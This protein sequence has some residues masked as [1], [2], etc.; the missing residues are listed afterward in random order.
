MNDITGQRCDGD[1]YYLVGLDQT[2]CAGQWESLAEQGLLNPQRA[3]IPNLAEEMPG[4]RLPRDTGFNWL[5]IGPISFQP[6]LYTEYTVKLVSFS[7]NGDRTYGKNTFSLSNLY[8]PCNHGSVDPKIFEI[9]KWAVGKFISDGIVLSDKPDFSKVRYAGLSIK[10]LDQ[11][12]RYGRFDGNPPNTFDG[13]ILSRQNVV[14]FVPATFDPRQDT[15]YDGL[16]VGFDAEK[17]SHFKMITIGLHQ[18][19]RIINTETIPGYTSHQCNK[20]SWLEIDSDSLILPKQFNFGAQD[21]PR[22]SMMGFP[23]T[24]PLDRGVADLANWLTDQAR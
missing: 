4:Y 23:P 24:Y 11:F 20:G 5:E 18:Q 14:F 3:W 12:F 15:S 19:G 2:S 7:E 9:A 13:Q 22:Y 16:F 10:C 8:P 1:F 17:Q 21:T 6:E